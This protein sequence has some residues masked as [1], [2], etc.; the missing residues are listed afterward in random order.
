MGWMEKVDLDGKPC[1]DPEAGRPWTV[2]VS[3]WPNLTE[4]TV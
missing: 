2:E 1:I 3:L 4:G